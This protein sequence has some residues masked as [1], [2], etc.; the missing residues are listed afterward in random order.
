MIGFS[1]WLALVFGLILA[2]AGTNELRKH[3]GFRKRARRARA[4]VVGMHQSVGGRGGAAP[5]YR[6]H[7]V[8]AFRTAEGREVQ[9]RT[10][11]GTNPPTAR[12]GQ[13]V[14]VVYDP[15]DPENVEITG[16]GKIGLAVTLVLTLFGF[17]LLAVFG[18]SLF[19]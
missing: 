16:K 5:Q 4:L 14:T 7:P 8:L 11:L 19:V 12:E 6:Y 9:A 10:N 13:R 2:V 17:A 18:F 3:A 1:G 15:H